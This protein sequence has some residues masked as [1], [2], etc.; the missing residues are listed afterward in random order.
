MHMQAC[1]G[2]VW[3]RVAKYSPNRP[4][5]PRS[6]GVDR[7]QRK[8]CHAS[9]HLASYS[10]PLRTPHCLISEREKKKK[11]LD[12]SKRAGGYSSSQ[13][14]PA[15][16]LIPPINTSATIHFGCHLPLLISLRI[17]STWGCWWLWLWGVYKSICTV[18]TR[19]PYYLCCAWAAPAVWTKT[20]ASFVSISHLSWCIYISAIWPI[21]ISPLA[22]EW[23]WL[24][25][26]D[27]VECAIPFIDGKSPVLS[28]LSLEIFASWYLSVAR[29]LQRLQMINLCL[30]FQE[31]NPLPWPALECCI[32]KNQ[33]IFWKRLIWL[34]VRELNKKLMILKNF[35]FCHIIWRWNDT[36][37]S[38]C[39]FH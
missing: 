16:Y 25:I 1:V 23:V 37:T 32:D 26:S 33:Y 34:R 30:A 10:E 12:A 13:V 19:Q 35:T 14:W 22:E 36:L 2:W 38:V 8:S 5:K 4:T 39:T 24:N 6:G 28:R 17:R 11:Q 31:G 27:S 7:L 18:D 21:F 29:A 15:L 3:T 9:T 20:N